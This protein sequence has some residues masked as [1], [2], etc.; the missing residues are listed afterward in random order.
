MRDKKTKTEDFHWAERQRFL[1]FLFVL[2]RERWFPFS[3]MPAFENFFF[4]SLELAAFSS[5]GGF[6]HES[7][8][9]RQLSAGWD[10]EERETPKEREAVSQ[11]MRVWAPVSL[12]QYPGM[13]PLSP[14]KPSTEHPGC[15]QG[16]K[17]QT[18]P[19]VWYK[20]HVTCLGFL[21]PSRILFSTI[22]LLRLVRDDWPALHTWCEANG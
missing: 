18:H 4:V 7:V 9:W 5:C 14:V 20:L 10:G 21:F 19:H 3:L 22:I 11:G 2:L 6:P 17:D 8:G 13:P 15:I 12:H 16:D 1:T